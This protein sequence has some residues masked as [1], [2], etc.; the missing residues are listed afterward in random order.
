[1][2][3]TMIRRLW[4]FVGLFVSLALVTACA[5][6]GKKKMDAPQKSEAKMTNSASDIINE[7]GLYHDKKLGVK[8]VWDK[9]TFTEKA[10][11][12][13]NMGEVLSV[14]YAQRVPS[15]QLSINDKT[16]DAGPLENAGKAFKKAYKKAMTSSKRFKLRDDK[17]ITLSNGMKANYAMMTWK[18]QGSISLVTASVT[19]YKGDK[20]IQ[21]TCT[22]VPASPGIEVMDGWVKAVVVDM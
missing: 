6:A 11:L 8:L 2:K 20:I 15:L 16:T 1:M 4:M 5:P 12:N 9:N 22:S 18:Y 19:V 10:D 13:S 14:V 21:V 17:M 7:P 3:K